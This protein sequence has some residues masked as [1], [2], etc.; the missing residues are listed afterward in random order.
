MKKVVVFLL[1]C[2]VGMVVMGGELWAKGFETPEK[3]VHG[4][5]TPWYAGDAEA[6]YAA[7]HPQYKEKVSFNKYSRNVNFLDQD[8]K[9]F[10]SFVSYKIV[11]I[12]GEGDSRLA[13]VELSEPDEEAYVDKLFEIIEKLGDQE[14]SDDKFEAEFIKQMQK[15][16][17]PLVKKT[18][19]VNVVKTGD[20]WYVIFD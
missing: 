4:F 12:N 17:I 9:L 7:L 16:K 13:V 8:E 20:G 2:V 10:N 14:I 5:Y 3:A 1:V 19:E 18:E 6:S 11:S 15:A